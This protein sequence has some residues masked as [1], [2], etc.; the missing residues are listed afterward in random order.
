MLCQNQTRLNEPCQN[1]LS[2]RVEC[3]K[4]HAVSCMKQCGRSC[5]DFVEEERPEKK[6]GA[7]NA[8]HRSSGSEGGT[9]ARSGCGCG[10]SKVLASENR[11]LPS[12][13]KF[14]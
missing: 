7:S 10:A 5:V 2:R 1:G 3:T 12:E 13:N 9:S 14:I 6:G 11:V 8:T 4:G